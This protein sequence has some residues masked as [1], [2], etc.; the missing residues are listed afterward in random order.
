MS[1]KGFIILGVSVLVLLEISFF[2]WYYFPRTIDRTFEGVV[3]Q[4]G[5]ENQWTIPATIHV[6]GKFKRSFDGTKTFTGKIEIE[7]DEESPVPFEKKELTVQM[8]DRKGFIRYMSSERQFQPYDDIYVNSDLTELTIIKNTP[9]PDN[10]RIG[11]W[12]GRDGWM[13]SAPAKSREEALR[14]SNDLMKD[15]LRNLLLE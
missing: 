8:T 4:L 2:V 12:N 1:K 10:P 7:E 13:I 3:Y 15:H 6:H 14:I 9:H 11:R 5:K